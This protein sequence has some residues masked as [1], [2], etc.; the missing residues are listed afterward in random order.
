MRKR[1]MRLFD[2]MVE[3]ESLERL[4]ALAYKGRT[5]RA[6]LVRTAISEYLAK[7]DARA[8]RAISRGW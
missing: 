1:R 2:L 8:K 7:E 4:R 3:E 5:S 6:Q